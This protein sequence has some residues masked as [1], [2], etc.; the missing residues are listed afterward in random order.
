MS[1]ILVTVLMSVYNEEKNIDESIQSILAQTY[2]NF[3]FII[4]DDASTDSTV[5]KILKYE[6]K[7]I[8]LIQNETNYGLTK[9][10]NRGLKIAKGKYILRMDGDDISLP[11]RFEKQVEFM[12]NHPEIALSG[13]WI[14]KFGEFSDIWRTVTDSEV[15]KIN[16]IFNSVMAHPTF[17]IR[18]E[19]IDNYGIRYDERIP[20]AQDYKFAYDVSLEGNI[21]NVPIVLLKYRTHKRQISSDKAELQIECA[22]MTRKRI[23]CDMD[24][25]LNDTAFR[26]WCDFCTGRE[27]NLSLQNR[28][29]LKRIVKLFMEKNQI[30]G[31]YN[32]QKLEVQMNSRLQNYCR[33]NGRIKRG[34]YIDKMR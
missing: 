34:L 12:E 24:I 6:D 26:L 18:K 17:I 32:E 28:I 4:F 31:F 16:L 22:N 13:C 9:N 27:R 5:E 23:L 33:N 2:T 8:L 25:R 15:L 1:D 7:R 20:Y 30:K 14:K 29:M 10:L 21:M 19:F 11:N 3:E